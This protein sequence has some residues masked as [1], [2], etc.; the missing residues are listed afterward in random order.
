MLGIVKT[1]RLVL[2]PVH[3]LE[4]AELHALLV[5]E[6]VRR[7]L[8]DGA[9]VSREWVEG[10]IRDSD[11]SFTERGLGLWSA[12]EHGTTS[13]IG[14][15]GFRDFYDPPVFE[16][17]Y[18]LRPSHW[19]RGFATEM[20]QAAIDHAFTHTRLTEVRA[21][22]DE[23]NQASIRVIERLGM[24]SYGRTSMADSELIC[25][26]QLHFVLP[27]DDWKSSH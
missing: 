22:T 8:T 3:S 10:V 21:S 23:P 11:A 4:A 16:L 15:T 20:A 17:L 27:R 13:I 1:A 26:D 19:R 7:Y 25:W 18:A 9:I 5:N 2:R 14:L 24:R 6:E 12:R